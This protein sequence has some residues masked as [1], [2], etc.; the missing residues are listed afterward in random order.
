MDAFCQNIVAIHDN[1]VLR[2]RFTC[3]CF[4]R[5]SCDIE[6]FHR[7]RIDYD[8][9][10]LCHCL[11]IAVPGR[12]RDNRLAHKAC[13][14]RHFSVDAYLYVIVV[15]AVGDITAKCF[16]TDLVSP[17]AL[18][19]LFGDTIRSQCDRVGRF[20]N[21]ELLSSGIR[22]AVF[23]NACDRHKRRR[24]RCVFG[25]I[26][27][28]AVFNCIVDAFCQN[29]VAVH[30]DQVLRERFTGVC[31]GRNSC[32]VEFFHGSRFLDRDG[33]FH[34]QSALGAAVSAQTLRCVCGGN[35]G[36]P[37]AKSSP[38]GIIACM[39]NTER[40]LIRVPDAECVLIVVI[41]ITCINRIPSLRRSL[42]A[43]HK[44][45]VAAGCS[46]VAVGKV[47]QIVPVIV[48]GDH[49]PH[50]AAASTAKVHISRDQKAPE[51]I[52]KG[53]QVKQ[54]LESLG[55]PLTNDL[56]LG[57]LVKDPDELP[58]IAIIRGT[59]IR[60]IIG[61]QPADLIAVADQL[62]VVI[63]SGMLFHDRSSIRSGGSDR[64]TDRQ[65]H[66]IVI[67][68]ILILFADSKGHRIVVS[69]SD[70]GA[71]MHENRERDALHLIKPVELIG[72]IRKQRVQALF[73]FVRQINTELII[74]SLR[75]FGGQHISSEVRII[76]SDR[77]D[78]EIFLIPLAL[79]QSQVLH[80][81]GKLG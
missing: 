68:R 79:L 42:C 4:G 9:H 19:I 36:L 64:L 34:F 17:A 35:H 10:C 14:D 5:N 75:R 43:D 20:F 38:A 53:R 6:F 71:C 40:Q 41:E 27:I 44:E 26:R 13:T 57:I 18:R 37:L 12:D 80:R 81:N 72:V 15:G 49:I 47:D 21:L 48:H 8:R 65:I 63:L 29:I 33:L 25:S 66:D 23:I 74:C 31:F 28:I 62:I 54:I 46:G 70:I 61:C 22:I 77:L 45:P 59:E 24:V 60:V 2:K 73:K 58:R 7:N 32:D 55:I 78:P 30:N 56:R 67:L 76:H 52:F 69:H 50:M 51:V 1:Q 11:V 39:L 3:V 16:R